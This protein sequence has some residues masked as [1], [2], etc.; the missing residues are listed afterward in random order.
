MSVFRSSG[1]LTA[2]QCAAYANT[3]AGLA[4][5]CHEMQQMEARDRYIRES[6]NWFV[7]AWAGGWGK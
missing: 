4:Q 1:N 7:L 3:A 5:R 2:K 6:A